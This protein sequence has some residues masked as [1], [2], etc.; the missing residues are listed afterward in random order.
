MRGKSA[1]IG[2]VINR[3]PILAETFILN[4]ILELE[5]NGIPLEIFCLARPL[6][7]PRHGTLKEVRTPVTLLP[8]DSMPDWWIREERY[9]EGT[10]LQQPFKD[11]FPPKSPPKIL[12]PPTRIGRLISRLVKEVRGI[13]DLPV[14]AAKI[15]AVPRAAALAALARA[16][17]VGHLHAHFGTD[18]TTVAMLA[19]RLSGLPYSF[20]AHAYDIYDRSRV[21][22]VLL[23]EKIALAQFVATC[24]EYN[25]RTLRKLAGRVAARKIIRVYHG[26][27]LT[28]FRPDPLVQREP[29]TILAVGRLVDKK[30]FPYLLHALKALRE[31]G[32]PFRCLI[33]GEG[34]ERENLTR[35]IN[36][37]GLGDLVRLPGAQPQ[38]QA[39]SMM[40]LATLFVLPCV[41]SDSGNRDGLPNA[42]VQALAVGLPAISTTLSGIPELIEHGTN[43]LLVPPGDSVSLASAMDQM[44]MDPDLRARLAS[45][46]LKRV[47]ESFDL[48]KT[49]KTLQ[50]RLAR[51]ISVARSSVT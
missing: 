39:L 2:Y 18:P 38:E 4:E 45:N 40:R 24:T 48:R 29:H 7:E 14:L 34:E 25:R 16:K 11:L 37:S 22:L 15:R 21:N 35:Q 13:E 44:L 10:F 6:D 30:G 26:A 32:R 23:K 46:G 8:D 12:I 27:D 3:F 20:S 9:A 51:S 28:R 42:L 17:G 36:A 50:D 1:K 41:V 49:T 47:T 5:R 31:K 43:G 33:V 19:S